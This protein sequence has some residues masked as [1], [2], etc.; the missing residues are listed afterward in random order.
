MPHYLTYGGRNGAFEY[1][2]CSYNEAG[3]LFNDGTPVPVTV[4][5]ESGFKTKGAARKAGL[6]AYDECVARDTAPHSP[7]PRPVV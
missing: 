7:D 2:F 5:T 6:D 3:A 4:K 1:H